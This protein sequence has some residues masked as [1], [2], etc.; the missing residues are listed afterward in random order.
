MVEARP[1]AHALLEQPIA[2]L[3]KGLEPLSDTV[4]PPVAM[5]CSVDCSM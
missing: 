3:A 5:W 1:I 4:E 2:A